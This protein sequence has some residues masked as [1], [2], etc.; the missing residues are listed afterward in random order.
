LPVLFLSFYIEKNSNVSSLCHTE[1]SSR[2]L[3]AHATTDYSHND[4]ISH[5]TSTL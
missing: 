2:V 4:W 5:T 3:D 1:R